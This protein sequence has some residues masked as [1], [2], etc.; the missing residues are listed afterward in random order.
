MNHKLLADLCASSYKDHTFKEGDVEVLH[1][2]TEGAHIY[3]IRG[4]ELDSWKDIFRNLAFWSKS[5]KDIHGHAGYVH[6]WHE[7]EDE[8]ILH[9]YDQIGKGA[10]KP[11]ILTGHS[12]GG[13]IALAGAYKLKLDRE[14]EIPLVECVTFGAPRCLDAG[15]MS[16]E[17]RGHMIGGT[18]QYI[19]VR[20]QV[21]QM[22]WYTPFDHIEKV[23]VGGR[24]IRPFFM[25]T[26]HAIEVYQDV[27]GV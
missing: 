10:A 17:M 4:T 14:K 18:T 7:I 22:L 21:P 27:M 25:R 11:M 5:T 1:E 16:D 9:Y 3:A 12:A 23:L 2:E 19:H 24:F 8:L 26:K 13:S 6:G 15:S 20:D